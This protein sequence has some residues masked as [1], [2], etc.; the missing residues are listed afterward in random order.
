MIS[1]VK[2]RIFIKSLVIT[3][4]AHV[5]ILVSFQQA[6]ENNTATFS[7]NNEP[8]SQTRSSLNIRVYNDSK[9]LLN[10]IGKI[11]IPKQS[12]NS[13]AINTSKKK[14]SETKGQN[15]LLN[16]YLAEV[17]DSI[18]RNKHYPR[19]AKKLKQEGLAIVSFEIHFPNKIKNIKLKKQTSYKILNS[20]A[21]N[22]VIKLKDIAKI[23]K[24]LKRKLIKIEVPLN[25]QTL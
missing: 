25:Y 18:L 23:P 14:V 9:P 21:I 16:K 19:V 17:R 7:P 6:I 13:K 12:K 1:S 8:L 24:S 10:K 15:K 11:K 20:S 5:L 3:L 2:S 22:T 4:G